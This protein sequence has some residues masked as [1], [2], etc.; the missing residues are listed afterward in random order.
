MYIGA[1]MFKVFV[2]DKAGEVTAVLDKEN[3]YDIFFWE[4]CVEEESCKYSKENKAQSNPQ[5]IWIT[6]HFKDEEAVTK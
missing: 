6:T 5:T 3:R 4:Y 2:T 1:K